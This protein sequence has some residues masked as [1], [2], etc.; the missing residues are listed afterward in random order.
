MATTESET[1]QDQRGSQGGLVY[2]GFISYS[3]A[4]DDLLAPRLQAGLQRFAKPWWKRRAL[5]IFRDESSLSANPHLWSS[6]TDALDASGWFVLL[7]SPDAAAS[8]WVNNEVEYWLEHKDPDR[9]IPVLTDGDFT[10]FDEDFIS[11]AAPPALQG[12]FPDEPRWV[13]LRFARTDEQLDLSN[14]Q[15]SAAVADIASA[16]HGVPKD[17]LE[18]EEVTQHRRTRRTA[19]AAAVLLIVLLLA[20]TTAAL[21]ALGQRNQAQEQQAAAE[22]AAGAET[23]AR[24]EADENA[25]LAAESAA[26]AE[27]QAALATA[28]ELAAS[29]VSAVER[30]PELAL[31]LT[32]S[33]FEALP[34]GEASFPEGTVALRNALDRHRLLDVITVTSGERTAADFTA[35]GDGL[36]VVAGSERVL[37]R[38]D[39]ETRE[40]LWVYEDPT[41][42]DLF[43]SVVASPDGAYVA[44]LVL[45]ETIGSDAEANDA[46]IDEQGNDQHPER[47]VVLDALSG[48]EVAVFRGEGCPL[49]A[50][51]RVDFSPDGSLLVVPNGTAAC[52]DEEPGSSW[53]SIVGTTTWTE[54]MRL[55]VPFGDLSFAADM[56][57]VLLAGGDAEPRIATWPDLRTLSPIDYPGRFGEIFP[58]GSHAVL[59]GADDL[60][61]RPALIATNSGSIVD[62]IDTAEGFVVDGAISADSGLIAIAST[63]GVLVWQANGELLH[64][65]ASPTA[66]Q[67]EFSPD[68]TTIATSHVDGAVRLWDLSTPEGTQVETDI[69]E[70][71][72]FNPDTI[73]EGAHTGIVGF[74]DHSDVGIAQLDPATGE[75]LAWMDAHPWV[76][77]LPD[78]R[79]LLYLLTGEGG[80]GTGPLVLWNPQDDTSEVI[81]DCEQIE[82]ESGAWCTNGDPRFGIGALVSQD[83]SS[84]GAFADVIPRGQPVPFRIWD[85]ATLA[86]IR[87]IEVELADFDFGRTPFLDDD[88]LLVLEGSGGVGR[89]QYRVFDPRTGELKATLDDSSEWRG[90]SAVNAAGDRVYLGST[91]GEVFEY[92]TKTWELLRSWVA[93][94]GR[95][96]GLALSPDGSQLLSTGEDGHVMIWGLEDLRLVDRIPMPFPSDAMW[97]DEDHLG[98]ALGPGKWQVSSLREEELLAQARSVLTRSYTSDECRFYVID[99]C[100][101]LEEIKTGSA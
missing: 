49:D 44:L 61:L 91:T 74:P 90:A 18:S 13:D 87:T 36:F 37:T 42:I 70:V 95:L 96:R 63:A 52:F 53:L 43:F 23:E 66:T 15:F 2:D 5:R 82:T 16:I 28:R 69:G 59:E 72:W 14:P 48:E 32:L 7:L 100:P 54:T 25:A 76:D 6:I 21:Y 17:E 71:L 47:V 62:R 8:A 80:V 50:G 92:N 85:A 88:S 35:D 40:P 81:D 58:D 34:P 1:S 101:S 73:S 68:G 45:D 89:V 93:Q 67:V 99:P 78:G 97:I 24:I 57:T 22:A 20:A 94:D 60:D 31:L 12:A 86:P 56:Q 30:N 77:Q 19:W 75:T 39:L 98:V 9:I 26:T 64:H 38:L 41:T 3:H 4:A 55:D 83:G 46:Q 10:W 11:D 84:I 33:S 79:F 65:F 27:H 29:G 51:A